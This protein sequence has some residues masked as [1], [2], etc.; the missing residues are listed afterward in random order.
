[1]AQKVVMM[2]QKLAAVL[3]VGL[4][5]SVT[6]LCAHLEISRQTFYKY[7]RRW[8]LE[9]PAGLIERSRRPVRCPGQVPVEIEERIVRLRKEL[10]LDNGA[11]TI[12][13]HLARSGEVDIVPSVATIHRVLVRRGMVVAQPEK[14]PRSAWRR[15]E[16]ARPN[17]A[18]QIDATCW[19]LR[20]GREVWVMDLL[21]DHSRMVI[22]A[23]VYDGP[24][25]E[26]AW[27]AFCEATSRYGIPAHVMSDN[28]TCF[29]AKRFS[30]GEAA[31][32]RDLRLLGVRHITSTPGHPQ[33]CGKIERFHQTMK[34]WL[35]ARPLARTPAELQRQLDEFLIFYNEQR[36]HRALNGA[37]PI[38]RWRASARAMPSNPIPGIAHASTH[39]V[40]HNA[41]SW[42]KHR[43]AVGPG[44]NHQPVVIIARD[45]DLA[46][47]GPDGLIR[48]L[49]LDRTRNYQPTT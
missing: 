42:G 21:D 15:F 38:E 12:A 6:E 48:R 13:Y 35:R 28:G 27:G 1:M 16:W 31:F 14:R 29:T 49:H 4:G 26:A 45:D 33:T 32:E 5:V 25:S 11:Q 20:S 8:D 37:T 3:S 46:V 22:A 40:T 9:G 39:H 18:W 43:I 34:R 41:V 36:P 10:P 17:D 44:R 47:F 2:E 19:A 23:R 7:R 24:T 30:G